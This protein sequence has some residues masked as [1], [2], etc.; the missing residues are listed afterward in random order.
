MSKK[1]K[2]RWVSNDNKGE[3]NEDALFSD[4][5]LD[6][7]IANA[8]KGVKKEIAKKSQPEP[9]RP[10]ETLVEHM[11][12]ENEKNTPKVFDREPVPNQDQQPLLHFHKH[13]LAL[14]FQTLRRSL[15]HYL[16]L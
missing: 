11:L 15:P 16:G 4:S 13:R 9:P 10:T 8:F 12:K 7:M 5:A 3:F 1:K 14:S 6:A 2:M